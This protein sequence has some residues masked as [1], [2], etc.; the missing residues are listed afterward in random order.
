MTGRRAIVALSAL[1]VLVSAYL[2]WVHWS[3][4]LALC[5]GVGGC[6]TVQTSRF[7]EVAG[8]PVALLGAIG[9]AGLGALGLLRLR[10]EPA[11]WTLTAL[12]GL[13]FGATLYAAYLTYLELAVIGAICP[14]CVSVATIVTAIFV[15]AVRE[16]ADVD[17]RT[18]S[19]PL[20]PRARRSGP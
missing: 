1:G 12:F 7:A 20:Q 15:L 16:L 6:E 19:R 2:T 5:I 11:P 3:G 4:E 14:W 17:G 18:I 8:V 10:A 13:A 9:F